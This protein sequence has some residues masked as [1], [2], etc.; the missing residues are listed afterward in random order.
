MVFRCS[1]DSTLSSPVLFFAL[2]VIT[3]HFGRT[4]TKLSE[5]DLFNEACALRLAAQFGAGKN[6]CRRELDQLIKQTDF[7]K[8]ELK[9]L[10]WGWKCSCPSGSLSESNFK[11]IYA[12]FFPQAGESV[13][14]DSWVVSHESWGESSLPS[15]GNHPHPHPLHPF[16]RPL[17][18]SL[19]LSMTAWYVFPLNPQ[20]FDMSFPLLSL[21]S[22]VWL[23]LMPFIF[24]LPHSMSFVYLD[25]DSTGDSSLY[26]RH[27]YRAMF[28]MKTGDVT[29]TDYAIALSGLSRG[30]TKDKLLWTFKVCSCPFLSLPLPAWQNQADIPSKCFL[31]SSSFFSHFLFI[32]SSLPLV[33]L[34]MQMRFSL[35]LSISSFWWK[36][37]GHSSD[38]LT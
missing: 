8:S 9:L 5:V 13:T 32:C 31:P 26:A 3:M 25:V 12:Q 7:T 20:R 2:F 34:L 11:E 14:H 4:E 36:W 19:M 30:S 29:F 38:P 1:F 18:M 6:R 16:L 28:G 23:A 24:W 33:C 15:S 17:F 21:I 22:S 27:V 10:Y 37:T 35:S